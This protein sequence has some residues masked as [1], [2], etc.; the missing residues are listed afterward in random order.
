M[1][2]TFTLTSLV[3]LASFSGSAFAAPSLVGEKI[4]ARAACAST[5]NSASGDTCATIAAAHGLTAAD[6]QNANTFLNC[7]DIWTNT[8]ICVPAGG[9]TGGSTTTPT[10]SST[11]NSASGDNC[12][13]IANKYGLTKAAI[14]SA[15]SFVNCDDIWT[16]TPICI[17]PGGTSN[18]GG[19]NTGGSGCV[20]TYISESGDSCNSLAN[21]FG[22]SA[23]AIQNANSFVNCNDI[24][25]N[26]ALCIPSGGRV[27]TP[28][29]GSASDCVVTYT[30]TSGD[31]CD[32]IGQKFGL[33]SSDVQ[34]A[35]NWV[36]CNDIWS[37]T[38]L[39][40]VSGC[41]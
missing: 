33:D 24:W 11:Y 40:I 12:D 18:N 35:N 17:P 38:S 15:N 21:D 31:N 39:C 16:N 5:I 26:T 8:P 37:G 29:S 41:S 36:N 22:L 9:S 23:S 32:N 19:S 28:Q 2:F 6:I 30:S 34:N 13:T 20:M 25:A 1:A 7:N 3:A 14:Q 10:C 27:S 4:V